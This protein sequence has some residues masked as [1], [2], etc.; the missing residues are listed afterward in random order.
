MLSFKLK[1]YKTINLNRQKEHVEEFPVSILVLI[2]AKQPA[3]NVVN[4]KHWVSQRHGPGSHTPTDV[5]SA[6]HR[7][8]CPLVTKEKLAVPTRV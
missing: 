1:R 5:S 6:L 3:K 8:I 4:I 7:P 2:P